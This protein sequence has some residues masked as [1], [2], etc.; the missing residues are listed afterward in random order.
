MKDRSKLNKAYKTLYV[1]F[2]IFIATAFLSSYIGNL[3]DSHFNIK[4]AGTLIM[5]GLSY[6]V[7]WIIIWQY[8]KRAKFLNNKED[9][10]DTKLDNNN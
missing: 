8:L 3:I 9:V 5:L 6:G 10:S 7:T 2:I 1:L 4:P